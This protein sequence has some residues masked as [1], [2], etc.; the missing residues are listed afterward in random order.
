MMMDSIPTDDQ[1]VCSGAPLLLVEDDEPLRQ[2][3][4]WEL[5]DLGYQVCAASDCAGARQFVR[6]QPLRFALIDVR[7]PDGD[8]RALSAELAADLPAL[9]IVLMSAAHDLR[10]VPEDGCNVLAFLG[11]PVNLARIHRV[12]AT[13]GGY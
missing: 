9:D 5:T 6:R 3:L 8:G 2:M 13:A 11:K 7:L 1:A 12:L 4:S 10:P